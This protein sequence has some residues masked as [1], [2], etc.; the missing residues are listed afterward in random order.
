MFYHLDLSTTLHS[1]QSN[2][3]THSHS[4][5]FSMLT[6]NSHSQAPSTNF[7]TTDSRQSQTQRTKYHPYAF[8]KF[9]KLDL[10]SAHHSSSSL[11]LVWFVCVQYGPTATSGHSPIL[12][13]LTAASPSLATH[14]PNPILP[15]P[16]NCSLHQ[17]LSLP[18]L[19]LCSSYV[20][21]HLSIFLGAHSSSQPTG[22]NSSALATN[23]SDCFLFPPLTAF[24]AA[25]TMQDF[26]TLQFS[27]EDRSGLLGSSCSTRIS[28]QS[29]FCFA[30]K[31]SCIRVLLLGVSKYRNEYSF[32]ETTYS[33]C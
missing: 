17:P 23:H 33:S 30:Y 18:N 27:S 32:S 12:F 9:T 1:R 10:E 31:P 19:S 26:N 14:S 29:T 7:F 6:V 11:H 8:H 28:L 4:F 15:G 3:L 2:T 24:S 25:D 5:V 16:V 13:S 22:F 20:S 21:R